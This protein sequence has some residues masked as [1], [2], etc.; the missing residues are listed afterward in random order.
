MQTHFA[1]WFAP[2]DSGSF[3]KI[4]SPALMSFVATI[5]LKIKLHD[6]NP[7]KSLGVYNAL[8]AF[9]KDNTM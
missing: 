8:V 3:L 1:F 9:N 2:T 4:N 5:Y 6:D 7:S